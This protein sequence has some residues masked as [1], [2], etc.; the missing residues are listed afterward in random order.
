MKI[1]TKTIV[2]FQS[3]ILRIT[4]FKETWIFFLRKDKKLLLVHLKLMMLKI[5]LVLSSQYPQGISQAKIHA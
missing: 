2:P 5:G 1:Q 3:S 4:T